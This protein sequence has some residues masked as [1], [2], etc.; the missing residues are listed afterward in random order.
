MISMATVVARP[1]CEKKKRGWESSQSH[2]CAAGDT[3]GGRR[4]RARHFVGGG[5]GAIWVRNGTEMGR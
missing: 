2:R 4:P 5:G 1:Q 3:R